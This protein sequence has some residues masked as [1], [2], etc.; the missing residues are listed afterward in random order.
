VVHDPL[1]KLV[2]AGRGRD[3]QVNKDRRRKKSGS[4]K[5]RE[6]TIRRAV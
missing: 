6:G 5:M 2:H 3:G 1:D 4:D